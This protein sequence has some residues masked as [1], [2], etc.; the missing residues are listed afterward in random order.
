MPRAETDYWLSAAGPAWAWW[1][2]AI[3]PLETST[4]TQI[5]SQTK[6]KKRLEAIGRILVHMKRQQP[7]GVTE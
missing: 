3:L 1:I 7:D 4:Q 5:L 2:L 6:L